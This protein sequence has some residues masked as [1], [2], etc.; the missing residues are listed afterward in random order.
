MMMTSKQTPTEKSLRTSTTSPILKRLTK[1]RISQSEPPSIS[2]LLLTKLLPPISMNIPNC[3]HTEPSK[4]VLK[5][6]SLRKNISRA[7][8]KSEKSKR[9]VSRSRAVNYTSINDDG[10]KYS[11]E[12]D[13][14]FPDVELNGMSMDNLNKLNERVRGMIRKLNDQL[15]EILTRNTIFLKA[16]KDGRSRSK[17]AE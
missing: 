8:L 14:S 13:K 15:N 10:N 3:R 6:Q 1:K 9:S 17:G 11:S 5:Q 7:S 12:V 2:H 16:K 4:T